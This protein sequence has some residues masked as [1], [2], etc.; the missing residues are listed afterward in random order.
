MHTTTQEYKGFTIEI[1]SYDGIGSVSFRFFV[2]GEGFK[3]EGYPTLNHAKGAITNFLKAHSVERKNVVMPEGFA[4]AVIQNTDSYK[5]S[6]NTP[7]PVPAAKQ[8][9]PVL[10][11]RNKREGHYFGKVAGEQHRGKTRKTFFVVSAGS[12]QN[13]RKQRKARKLNVQGHQSFMSQLAQ[14]AFVNN[15]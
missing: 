15:F 13:T 7:W 6:H 3:T 10:S 14:D 4:S 8:A 11:S 5:L 2:K 9:E 1:V 12:M